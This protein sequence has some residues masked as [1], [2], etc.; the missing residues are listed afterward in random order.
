MSW[1]NND[2]DQS[3]NH[4]NT[5][6]TTRNIVRGMGLGALAGVCAFAG[7]RYKVCQPHQ[8]MVRTGLG[9]NEM[10][11]SKHGI[12][13]PFQRAAFIDMNPVTHAFA[14]HNMSSE[15]VEFNLPIVI[16]VGPVDPDKNITNF[17]NYA[18]IMSNMSPEHVKDTI[19]GMVEGETRGLTAQMTIE[20]LFS[21]K[22]VFKEKVVTKIEQDLEKLGFCIYNANIKEMADYDANN[23]Y[24]EHRKKR[25][26]ETANYEAQVSV[27]EARK[28]GEI[29]VMERDRDSRIQKARLEQE[30]KIQENERNKAIAVSNADVAVI[31]AESMKRDEIANKE[32]VMAVKQKEMDLLKTLTEREKEQ[33]LEAMRAKK[34]VA[35]IVEAEGIE[36]LAEAKLLEQLKIAEGKKAILT[37]QADGL[38]DI[39][40]AAQ[41]PELAKFYLALNTDLYPNLAGKAA[42]AVQGLN[43]RVHIWNTGSNPGSNNDIGTPFTKLFQSFAPLLD[44]L[45]DHVKLPGSLSPEQ[46]LTVAKK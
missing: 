25:A 20:E 26:I 24:F 34:L 14:L 11:I 8:V 7:L 31:K 19:S 15:K 37:A 3:N 43:P 2:R 28:D 40:A 44:G 12:V 42:Q 23:K 39:I 32:K 21:K 27:A 33:Q 22:D 18:R 13:W 36:R 5:Y 9:I 38:R 35:S 10:K 17:M 16:T 41:C 46:G 6:F 1:Q 29:G 45:Q 30:A 4:L